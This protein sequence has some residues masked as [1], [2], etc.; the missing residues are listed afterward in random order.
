MKRPLLPTRYTQWFKV[1]FASYVPLRESEAKVINLAIQRAIEG[2][3]L[4]SP[5]KDAVF[6]PA[7][8]TKASKNP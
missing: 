2:A 3:S 5:L 4:E 1:E 6:N 7:S 8:F